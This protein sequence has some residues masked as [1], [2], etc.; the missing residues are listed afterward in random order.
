M[1]VG[2][3]RPG[4]SGGEGEVEGLRWMNYANWEENKELL[5]TAMEKTRRRRR[6]S[7]K[8][9]RKPS[10]DV[11]PKIGSTNR[12][13]LD[14]ALDE[15]NATV[16]LYFANNSRI[17]RNFSTEFSLELKPPRTSASNFERFRSNIGKQFCVL[18]K[19]HWG[20]ANHIYI[21]MIRV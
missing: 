3:R 18:E 4:A 15:T 17:E 2:R 8:T 10:I 11:K 20:E 1:G 13:H 19:A 6:C 5:R 12:S 7:L 21:Y 14:K 9:R 16:S